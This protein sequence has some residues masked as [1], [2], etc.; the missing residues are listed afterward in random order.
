MAINSNVNP[1]PIFG[2]PGND[3]LVG[4]NLGDQIFGFA[5]VWPDACRAAPRR[6]RSIAGALH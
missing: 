6:S 3:T 5:S 1:N 4:T 2:T